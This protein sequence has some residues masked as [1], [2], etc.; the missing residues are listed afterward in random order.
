MQAEQLLEA[1]EFQETH[2]EATPI[3]VDKY[4]RVIRF[5]LKPGQSIKEHH[6]PDSPFYV[7]ILKGHGLFS[8]A[9]G[10]AQRFGPN[11]LLVFSP[12]ED[13]DVKAENEELVFVGFL[14]GVRS[15]VS[16]KVGGEMGRKKAKARASTR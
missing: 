15:N 1:L 5:A 7:V 16:G 6:V 4:G 12:G 11:D 8:G 13:H 3:Y 14:H 2:P 9:D 10:K